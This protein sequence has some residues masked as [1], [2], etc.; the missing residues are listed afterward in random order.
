MNMYFGCVRL[1]VLYFVINRPDR[2]VCDC[3][4]SIV[5]IEANPQDLNVPFPWIILGRLAASQLH[6]EAGKSSVTST[7]FILIYSHLLVVVLHRNVGTMFLLTKKLFWP[8]ASLMTPALGVGCFQRDK[9]SN[10]SQNKPCTY[11]IMF[12][13]Q[14]YPYNI[15]FVAQK[16]TFSLMLLRNVHT[17]LCLLCNSAH[18][19]LCCCVMCI[20][21]YVCCVMCIQ[22]YVCC[23][24]CIQYYVCCSFVVVCG[25]GEYII[26]TAM[27]LRNKSFGQALEFV[28]SHDSS[29]YAIR[30]SSNTLQIYKNFKEHKSFKP[31]FGAEGWKYFRI[32]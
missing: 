31:D 27:A 11:N 18:I 2:P 12:V 9:R 21:Y 5:H 7:R 15:V 24:I 4:S 3:M 29:M 10:Q 6:K 32:T 16:C 28:W 30:E 13:A 14:Q 19:I 8:N 20:Q 26:Y 1:S 23:V 17:I 22:Y 25:D